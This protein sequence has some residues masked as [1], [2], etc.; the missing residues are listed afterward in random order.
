MMQDNVHS[1]RCNQCHIESPLLQRQCIDHLFF[2][3]PAVAIR[4][5]VQ[6]RQAFVTAGLPVP[7]TPS[8]SAVCC[9][10]G[11]PYVCTASGGQVQ[12]RQQELGDQTRRILALVLGAE[13]DALAGAEVVFCLSSRQR[14][15]SLIF[16]ISGSVEDLRLAR[17]NPYRC[18]RKVDSGKVR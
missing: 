16:S 14:F 4:E 12:E 6:N 7:P 11:I 13:R 10:F 1:Y 5:F 17:S 3:H 9:P 18:P 15:C 8:W 2:I